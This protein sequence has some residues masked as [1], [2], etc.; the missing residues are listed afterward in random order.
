MLFSGMGPDL[1]AVQ[2]QLAVG[3]GRDAAPNERDMR[4]R[5]DFYFRSRRK[6]KVFF[7]EKNGNFFYA[8]FCETK[9]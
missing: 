5:T 8:F 9:K 1:D 3:V 6:K 4:K 2:D 7:F